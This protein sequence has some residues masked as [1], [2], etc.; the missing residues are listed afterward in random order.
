M[1]LRVLPDTSDHYGEKRCL[2]APCLLCVPS[3]SH[4][5]GAVQPHLPG[6]S[7][8]SHGCHGRPTGT[9]CNWDLSWF[10]L[11][12]QATLRGERGAS[13]PG[14]GGGRGGRGEKGQ[15]AGTVSGRLCWARAQRRRGLAGRGSTGRG[16][17]AVSLSSVPRPWLP[18]P[19]ELPDLGHGFRNWRPVSLLRPTLSRGPTQA[20]PRGGGGVLITP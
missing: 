12:S 15:S 11:A 9:W 17:E 7:H 19:P 8:G 2:P 10:L 5:V 1:R 18:C 6:W 3:F 4:G 16:R 20:S 13:S 14:A